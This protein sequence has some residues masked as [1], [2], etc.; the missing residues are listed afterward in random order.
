[1]KKLVSFLALFLCLLTLL[2]SVS[3]YAA[4]YKS[5]TYSINGTPVDSPDAFTPDKQVNSAA[6]GLDKTNYLK[7]TGMDQGDFLTSPSDLVVDANDDVYIVDTNTNRVIVLDKYFKVKAQFGRAFVNDQGVPDSLYLP[8][9]VFVT[10]NDPFRD[11]GDHEDIDPTADQ[12][13]ILVA[14]TENRRIVVFNRSNY[15]FDYIID[16]PEADVMSSNAIY[17]PIALSVDS[18]GNLYVVSSSTYEGI[19][20]LDKKGEFQCYLGAQKASVDAAT[21]LWQSFMTAEQRAQTQSYVS[22]E[23]NNITIDD[24]GFIY[25]TTSS[26]DAAAQQNATETKASDYAPVKK[27][28]SSGD[29]VMAR[30]G[31]FGPGGE[32][33]VATGGGESTGEITGASKII[34]VALGPEGTWSIIDEKRSKV[35]TYDS[36]GRLLHVF[37]DKGDML[38]NISTAKAISYKGVDDPETEENEDGESFLILDIDN[39]NI[40]VY[41]RTEYGE[42]LITALRH[43]N[44]REYDVAVEDWEN[45]LKRNGNFDAAY[46][47]IGKSYYREGKWEKAMEYFKY[48]YDLEN[49]SEAFKEYRKEWISKYIIVVPI[50]VIVVVFGI[51]KLFGWASK[52]NKAG[53]LKQGKRKMHEEV[54]FAFHLFGHPFDGFWDLKHEKRGSVRGAT[55]WLVLAVL[56]FTYQGVGQ[57]YLFNPT[58]VTSSVFVQAVSVLMPFFL[59]IVANWCLTTLMDGE[60]SMKDIY[61]AVGYSTAPLPFFV[62]PSVLLTHV[63]SLNEAG[64]VSLLV[65]MAWIWVAVLVIFG[66]MVTHGYTMFTNLI[67]CILTVVGIAFIMF[68]GLLF[69]GLL[70]KIVG[71][72]T[73]IV[74]ELSFRM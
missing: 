31:F 26:I 58:G 16:A 47:G 55:F 40:T 60:G 1:M 4:A 14:D 36:Y 44:N 64:I 10:E 73:S 7:T 30:G 65:S 21:I 11:A 57:A 48:A 66:L 74:T 2:G 61:I 41:N 8:R 23:Y 54:L 20:V 67:T 3:V 9:G 52:V 22:T 69:T 17:K 25:V 32:V 43:D 34:D 35:Y 42:I 38:G 49:Y 24:E 33:N 13:K 56:S 37:G 46:V 68:I 71:F 28:N 53:V 50:V 5:Y 15:E 51:S 27:L 12:G 6:M 29:D 72:I 18:L 45:I 39:L 62:I 59:L 70:Q 63:F 19:I